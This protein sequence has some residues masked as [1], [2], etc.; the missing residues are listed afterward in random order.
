[1]ALDN[2]NV[3]Y[4]ALTRAEMGLTVFA[5]HPDNKRSQ[6]SVA[7]LLYDSILRSQELL[8]YY[9]TALS[10]LRM[11]S[12]EIAGGAPSA[13]PTHTVALEEYQVDSWRDKLVIRHRGKDFFEDP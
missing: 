5:P 2:L 10:E 1:T 9:N 12:F 13:V 4:V 3:L 11:G 6:K 8:K 7:V